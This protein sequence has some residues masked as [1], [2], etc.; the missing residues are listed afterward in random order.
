M[1]SVLDCN[2]TKNWYSLC[3]NRPPAHFSSWGNHFSSVTGVVRIAKVCIKA[4]LLHHN[5]QNDNTCSTSYDSLVA[6]TSVN[7][8]STCKL[9]VI[10]VMARHTGSF[11]IPHLWSCPLSTNLKLSL[12]SLA[13]YAISGRSGTDSKSFSSLFRFVR[14]WLQINHHHSSQKYA[15]FI[16][17]QGATD[18]K[19]H[20]SDLRGGRVSP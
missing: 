7:T 17:T 14:I 8:R 5:V 15:N 11:Q 18:Y 10:S 13:R 3:R 19:M 4:T 9:S 16:H 20:G 12:S 6:A 1:L 2:I